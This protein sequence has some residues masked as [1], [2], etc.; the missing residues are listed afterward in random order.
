MLFTAKKQRL[1]HHHRWWRDATISIVIIIILFYC[2]VFVIIL[3]ILFWQ[4][5]GLDGR[6]QKILTWRWKE[7]PIELAREAV[8]CSQLS[9]GEMILTYLFAFAC[10]CCYV[11]SFYSLFASRG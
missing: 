2:V 9:D 3:N 4:A 10:I 11:L 5:V 6:V 8:T 1:Q 7:V